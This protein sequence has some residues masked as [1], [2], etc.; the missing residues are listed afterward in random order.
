MTISRNPPRRGCVRWNSTQ[1]SN[2]LTLHTT[3]IFSQ[4]S[5]CSSLFF[6]HDQPLQG[7]PCCDCL[8]RRVVNENCI[9]DLERRI[10]QSTRSDSTF[11]ILFLSVLVARFLE[12]YF[13]LILAAAPVSRF[14]SG[15]LGVGIQHCRDEP[16]YPMPAMTVPR[17][18]TLRLCAQ[19]LR[20]DGVC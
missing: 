6:P 1:I 17:M 11:L 4:E 10:V 8:Q 2:S 5:T 19:G 15:M 18:M 12:I 20:S 13:S 9:T 14:M 16:L 7:R 3:C